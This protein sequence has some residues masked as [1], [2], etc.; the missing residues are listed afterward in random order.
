MNTER[1]LPWTLVV[2]R[3]AMALFFLNEARSQLAN[4]WIGGDGL[5]MTLRGSLDSHDTVSFY[6]PLLDHVVL[7]RAGF[8]TVLV[9]L[10]EIGVG[11]GLLL[12]AMTRLTCAAGLFMN[13][14]FLLMN[15]T[16]G[17]FTDALFIVLE[18]ALILFAAR[19]PV[20][21]DKVLAERGVANVWLSGRV[22]ASK[23]AI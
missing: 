6:R 1:W 2:V 7:P 16:N 12:G 18:L 4:G 3:V 8:F 15:G 13:I 17:G 14:N 11:A 10:G 21:I 23:A 19:Q 9:I 22:A 5:M 20:S